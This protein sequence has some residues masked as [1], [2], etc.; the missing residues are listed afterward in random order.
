[1]FRGCF[2]GSVVTRISRDWVVL[3]GVLGVF[4]WIGG[5]RCFKGLG[6][7]NVNIHVYDC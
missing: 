4:Q 6:G 1:M 7:I 3:Y 2:S 5:Y